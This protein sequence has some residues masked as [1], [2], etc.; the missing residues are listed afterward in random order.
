MK[1]IQIIL[2]VLSV[3]A[4]IMGSVAFRSKLISRLL[5][6]LLSGVAIGFVIFPDVTSDIARSIGVGRGTD[7]LL[8]A[9]IFAGLHTCLLLYMRTRAIQRK[10]TEL[11]RA[12]AIQNAVAPKVKAFS[13]H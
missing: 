12:L 2:I 5:A 6:L 1:S 4:A 3:I 11:T 8:Y 13:A 7:L 10:L 9:T